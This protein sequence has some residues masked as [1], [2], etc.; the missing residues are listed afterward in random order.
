MTK[1][2]MSSIINSA[3]FNFKE[4]IEFFA[5][6][7]WENEKV[8]SIHKNIPFLCLNELSR[9]LVGKVIILLVLESYKLT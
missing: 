6:K 9:S 3:N 5:N 7:S 8:N 2:K 1:Q 4:Y